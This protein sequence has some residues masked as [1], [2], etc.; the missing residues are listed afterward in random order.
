MNP[1]LPAVTPHSM[2]DCDCVE[3]WLATHL[4]APD[5]TDALVIFTDTRPLDQIGAWRHT[6]RLWQHRFSR[7]GP[8]Q[9]PWQGLF[10]PLTA[11][12]KAMAARLHLLERPR[13]PLPYKPAEPPPTNTLNTKQLQALA[14][15]L[16]HA[17]HV[18]LAAL[19]RTPLAGI[20]AQSSRDY[21]AAWALLGTWTCTLVWPTPDRAKRPKACCPSNQQLRERQPYLGAWARSSFEQ[22][23]LCALVA[24]PAT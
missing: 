2:V 19:S 4:P 22:G 10:V 21:L 8:Y 6:Q 13:V 12:H 15:A 5:A 23:A 11:R 17:E 14:T 7:T 24:T 18:Q 1:T 20:L 9:E 16:L 3:G